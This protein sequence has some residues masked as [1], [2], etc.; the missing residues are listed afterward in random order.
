M[1]EAEGTSDTADN[2]LGDEG[3]CML[4]VD[5]QSCLEVIESGQ[6]SCDDAEAECKGGVT[7]SWLRCVLRLKFPL[8]VGSNYVDVKITSMNKDIL[9]LGFSGRSTSAYSSCSLGNVAEFKTLVHRRM[10][11]RSFTKCTAIKKK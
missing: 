6:I 9:N 5:A 1:S 8:A 2:V 10:I 11:K 7:I 3:S 4:R